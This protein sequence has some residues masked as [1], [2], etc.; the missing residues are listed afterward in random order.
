[1]PDLFLFIPKEAYFVTFFF[2][3]KASVTDMD[4]ITLDCQ[5]CPKCL[6]VYLLKSKYSWCMLFRVRG[7]MFFMIWVNCAFEYKWKV[8][9]KHKN[10]ICKYSRHTKYSLV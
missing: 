4:F 2:F 10:N 7:N 9:H 5:K 8:T 6:S 1:M 3:I